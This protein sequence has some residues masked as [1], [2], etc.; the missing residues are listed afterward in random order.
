MLW[1]KGKEM[2]TGRF[3]DISDVLNLPEADN[4]CQ[5]V[6]KSAKL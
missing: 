1:G 2:K 5:R 3:V 4:A 6:S